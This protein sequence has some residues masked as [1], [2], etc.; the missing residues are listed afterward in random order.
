MHPP[1]PTHSPSLLL[2]FPTPWTEKR[3]QGQE[4]ERWGGADGQ[5][6]AHRFKYQ[7]IL[8]QSNFGSAQRSTLNMKDHPGYLLTTTFC[9]E[10]PGKSQCIK[11]RREIKN[12]QRAGE[13][14]L[15]WLFL[16]W[17]HLG[18]GF[19]K[20]LGEI[21]QAQPLT[22]ASAATTRETAPLIFSWTS[23]P[24]GTWAWQYTTMR[25]GGKH[26][27][28]FCSPFLEFLLGFHLPPM[29]AS[30]QAQLSTLEG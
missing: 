26:N 10:F 15:T 8:G 30:P 14:Q 6:L 18:L 2:L 29:R 4:E 9:L 19:F 24:D 1:W 11:P 3:K 16:V 7:D 21:A 12:W 23:H 5:H 28:S 27:S 25:R 22:Q 20:S 13:T 17:V